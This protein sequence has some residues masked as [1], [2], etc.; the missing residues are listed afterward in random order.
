VFSPEI[1]SLMRTILDDAT[2]LL[3]EADQTSVTKADMAAQILE[4]A[5]GGEQDP[6]AL[7]TSALSAVANHASHCHDISAA[8]RAV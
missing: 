4:L 6:I 5:V 1:M 8:R 2:A 3:P 7:R